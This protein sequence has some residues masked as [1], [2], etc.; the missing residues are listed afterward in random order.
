MTV[1][2]TANNM[3]VSN[4]VTIRYTVSRAQPSSRTFYTYTNGKYTPYGGTLYI[5]YSKSTLTID[6]GP[7]D[8]GSGSATLTFTPSGGSENVFT[9][10]KY[11]PEKTQI[12][13][14]ATY[15]YEPSDAK[16]E[17]LTVLARKKSK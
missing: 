6:G 12:Q 10:K 13:K 14:Y 7:N 15:L 1:I 8:T 5:A 11:T 3:T 4:A 16:K 2:G 17:T 9:Y